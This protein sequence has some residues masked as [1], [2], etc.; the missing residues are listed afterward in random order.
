[1]A[2]KRKG[3]ETKE[4]HKQTTKRKTTNKEEAIDYEFK[5]Y[6]YTSV[7]IDQLAQIALIAQSAQIVL[8]SQK[9]RFGHDAPQKKTQKNKHPE[10]T[11]GHKRTKNEQAQSAQIAQVAQIVL[12]TQR[13]LFGNGAPQKKRHNRTNTKNQQR[14]TNERKNAKATTPDH[15]TYQ[16]ARTNSIAA[17]KE[18]SSSASTT[19]LLRHS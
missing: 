10:Q 16:P 9:S 12:N 3:K 19:Q 15:K 8:T 5:T 13:S 18:P 7:T 2:T 1:M 17:K 11:K 14:D 4:A 6:A